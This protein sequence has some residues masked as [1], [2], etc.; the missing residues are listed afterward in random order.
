MEGALLNP[1]LESETLS[2][3]L[4]NIDPNYLTR[5]L[6]FVRTTL[7]MSLDEIYGMPT[8]M[9]REFLNLKRSDNEVERSRYEG[10][11]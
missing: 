11:R 3:S 2:S 10:L 6:Y 4:T 7:N 5:E 8:S 9:R 1:F